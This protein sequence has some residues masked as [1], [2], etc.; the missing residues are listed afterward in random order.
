[1]REL[2][3]LQGRTRPTSITVN[4]PQ[5]WSRGP[6]FR[7]RRA[8]FGK[9]RPSCAPPSAPDG[10]RLCRCVHAFAR[11]DEPMGTGRAGGMAAPGPQVPAGSVWL[12]RRTH[13]SPHTHTHTHT[14]GAGPCSLSRLLPPLQLETWEG[15]G[16]SGRPQPCSPERWPGQGGGPRP[17]Q[18]AGRGP[19]LRCGLRHVLPVRLVATTWDGRLAPIRKALPG[20]AGLL[21]AESASPRAHPNP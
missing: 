6:A 17:G 13:V 19:G 9:E 4:L 1:M 8:R 3:Q 21:E 14:P 11:A 20:E 12:Y 15:G 5:L 16:G 2:P 18:S 10:V 7:G